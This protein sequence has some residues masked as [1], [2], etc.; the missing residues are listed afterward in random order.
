MKNHARGE[1]LPAVRCQR[2]GAR[3]GGVARRGRRIDGCSRRIPPVRRRDRVDEPVQ[4]P[5]REVELQGGVGGERLEF[6]GARG[7]ENEVE[8]EGGGGGI[9]QESTLILRC[10]STSAPDGYH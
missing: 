8:Q 6:W 4:R 10:N 2:L 3:A 9:R 7:K 5:E 1:S